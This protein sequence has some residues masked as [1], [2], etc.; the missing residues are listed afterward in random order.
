MSSGAG[1]Q[2][3]L[4]VLVLVVLGRLLTP[5]DFGLVGVALVVVGFSHIFCQLGVGP[6]V[7]QKAEIDGGLLRVAFT[8]SVF[9]GVGFALLIFFLAPAIAAFFSQ[10]DPG[11]Q[12][13]SP[14]LQVI[15]LIFPIKGIGIVAEALLQRALRFRL[16]ASI[17]VISYAVG[18][19]G[20][21]VISAAAGMGAWALVF[22]HLTQSILKVGITLCF[23]RHPAWPSLEYNSVKKLSYFGSGFTFARI[24]NYFANQGDNVVVGRWLG[25]DAL[26]YY[27]RA[28]QL[29]AMPAVLIGQVLDK[30][31]FPLMAKVQK[32][33][34]QLAN[35][36]LKSVSLTSLLVLPTSVAL[37]I[38]APEVIELLLG[39]QWLAAVAPFQILAIGMLFRTNDRLN[40]SLARATGAVYS[41]ASLQAIYAGLVIAGAVIG[42]NW[43]ISG[44]AMG[45]LGA[46]V[47]NY[48]AGTRLSLGLTSV[49][50]GRIFLV[51]C[52]AI[53]LTLLSASQIGAI[54]AGLRYLDVPHAV[55]I[56][57]STLLPGLTCAAAIVLFPWLFLGKQG[58]E[59][60]QLLMRRLP[61]RFE[62]LHRLLERRMAIEEACIK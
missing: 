60:A 9:L 8:L 47:I 17:E 50:W 7:V 59:M 14:I 16:L 40:A 6:A 53:C 1:I 12:A 11:M 23:Q 4:Q 51:H 58:M 21:G 45:V 55:V 28:Y 44:V 19:G 48:A 25:A 2:G 52:P 41:R 38:L 13:L 36:Y 15:A 61:D 37:F 34:G 49:T 35:A 56:L 46:L 39:S 42:Q 22:A 5:A 20:V 27:G 26:G 54:A 33:K 10:A 43:G 3:V 24:A 30:V 29:M 32:Q 18:Y 31:L 62:R 57:G